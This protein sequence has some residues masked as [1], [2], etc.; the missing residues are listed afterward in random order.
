VRQ[1]RLTGAAAA[2]RTAAG[3]RA[4]RRAQARAKAGI[5]ELEV[6][7]VFWLRLWQ[8]EERSPT[9]KRAGGPAWARGWGRCREG[10]DGAGA[11]AGG[12]LRVLRPRRRVERREG[13]QALPR[14]G[15]VGQMPQRSIAASL[16]SEGRRMDGHYFHDKSR[17]R[18]GLTHWHTVGA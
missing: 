2:C 11:G 16:D 6:V 5:V 9:R 13:G 3:R 4:R 12:R 14:R 17:N 10:G 15:Q 1:G 7:A 8:P 18:P